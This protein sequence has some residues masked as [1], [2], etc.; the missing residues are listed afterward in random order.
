MSELCKTCPINMND[1]DASLLCTIAA[2]GAELDKKYSKDDEFIGLI[3]EALEEEDPDTADAAAELSA[4]KLKSAE[5]CAQY[6]LWDE[7]EF[8]SL[9]A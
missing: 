1:I 7:C 8:A 9:G 3:K 6:I 4:D 5:R 2:K